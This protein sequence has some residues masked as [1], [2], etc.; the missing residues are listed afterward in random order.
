MLQSFEDL[1]GTAAQKKINKTEACFGPAVS[2]LAIAWTEDTS[3][4]PQLLRTGR[5]ANHGSTEEVDDRQ[6][7]ALIRRNERSSDTS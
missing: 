7:I 3:S 5:H 6:K 2:A 1:I 4:A